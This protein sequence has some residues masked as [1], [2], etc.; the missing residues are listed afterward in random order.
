MTYWEHLWLNWRVAG[1][2]FLLA[3]FHLVHGLVPIRPT[4]HE[5]WGVGFNKPPKG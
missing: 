3:G 5:W 2:C 4:S 1:K